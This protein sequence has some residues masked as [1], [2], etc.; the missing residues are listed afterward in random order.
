MPTYV[1]TAATETMS[2]TTSYVGSALTASSVLEGSNAVPNNCEVSLAQLRLSSIA[3]GAAQVTW[4]LGSENG[5]HAITAERTDDILDAD[6]DNNGS[7]ARRVAVGYDGETLG[8][9]Y[10]WAK[11]DAGTASGIGLVTVQR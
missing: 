3:G 6:A 2:L 9:L 1:T 8:T 11:L 7:C 5:E 4:Y 10:L